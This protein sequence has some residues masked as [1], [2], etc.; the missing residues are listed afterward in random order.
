IEFPME[1]KKRLTEYQNKEIVVGIRPEH[2]IINARPGFSPAII[3]AEV[4][5]IEHMGHETYLYLTAGNKKMVCRQNSEF[6]IKTN[7]SVILSLD[8]E[9]LHFFNAETGMVI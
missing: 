6:N 3:E 9:K 4:E 1:L 7:S 2:L 5:V 8:L